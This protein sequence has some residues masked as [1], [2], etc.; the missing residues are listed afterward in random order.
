MSDYMPTESL[1]IAAYAGLGE[2]AEMVKTR[3]IAAFKSLQSV[4]AKAWDEGYEAGALDVGG[5]LRDYE[6]TPNPHQEGK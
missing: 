3:H 6:L 2:D 1:L 5:G 4:K